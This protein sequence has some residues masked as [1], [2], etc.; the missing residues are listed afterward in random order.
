MKCLKPD[1]KRRAGKVEYKYSN[2]WKMHIKVFPRNRRGHQFLFSTLFLCRLTT[3]KTK[4]DFSGK[5]RRKKKKKKE[6]EK[7]KVDIEQAND[8]HRMES[9]FCYRFFPA[10]FLIDVIFGDK[11]QINKLRSNFLLK[12]VFPYK[13]S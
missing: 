8:C 3:Q 1:D 4:N 5:R 9:E 2:S 11:R 12:N 6:E 7:K 13:S 10:Y